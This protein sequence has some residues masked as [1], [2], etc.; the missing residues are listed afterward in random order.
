[1]YVF[2]V[3]DCAVSAVLVCVSVCVYV[4]V[5]V[6]VRVYALI[7]SRLREKS[8]FMFGKSE[9]MK[10]ENFS[11]PRSLSKITNQLRFS[12]GG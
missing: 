3:C 7:N 4:C 12:S 1:M 6:C 5:Y 2:C 11:C 9:E 10:K 8:S